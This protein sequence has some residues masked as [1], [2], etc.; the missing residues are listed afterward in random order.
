[1]YCSVPWPQYTLWAV[2]LQQLDEEFPAE[3]PDGKQQ[4]PSH[5]AL[6]QQSLDVEHNCR[7]PAQQIPFPHSPLQ[8]LL[9]ALLPS[10]A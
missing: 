5:G 4:V 6:L 3:S 7:T 9:A 1:M 2:P 8:Q 10:Q